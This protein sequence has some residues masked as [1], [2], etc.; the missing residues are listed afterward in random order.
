MLQV[1]AADGALARGVG[2]IWTFFGSPCD[3]AFKLGG[4]EREL[5]RGESCVET[6]ILEQPPKAGEVSSLGASGEQLMGLSA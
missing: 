3:S 4:K 2:G 1:P 6:P 5:M